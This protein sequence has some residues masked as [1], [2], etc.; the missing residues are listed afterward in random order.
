[1]SAKKL[2]L[3]GVITARFDDYEKRLN[4]GWYQQM[5]VEEL[6]NEGYEVSAKYFSRCFSKAKKAKA[7]TVQ[8]ATPT[9][10]QP[11]ITSLDKPK[12]TTKEGVK[13]FKL[14]VLKDEELF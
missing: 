11:V 9:T 6:K 10:F 7:I 1:M 5:I 8:P 3:L 14:V 12:A 4:S 13:E 2:K